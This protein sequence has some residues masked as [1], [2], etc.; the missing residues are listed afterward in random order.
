MRGILLNKHIFYFNQYKCK[1]DFF[2]LF[3]LYST[4][5]Q[6]ITRSQVDDVINNQSEIEIPKP[7]QLMK[8][9]IIGAPNAGKSS[10]INTLTN[11]RVSLLIL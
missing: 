6:K 10:F 4:K 9:A 11:H 1:T 5:K 2:L 3:R 8:V 7:Q